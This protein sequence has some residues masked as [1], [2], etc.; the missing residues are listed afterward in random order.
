MMLSNI[1]LLSKKDQ[2]KF[3]IKNKADYEYAKEIIGTYKP[4]CSVFFQ[5]VWGTDPQKLA[6]WILRD[7]LAVRLGLQL[8]KIIW[9]EKRGV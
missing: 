3:I 2:L 8:Q 5:P 7:G 9:G 4:C 6:S 1:S